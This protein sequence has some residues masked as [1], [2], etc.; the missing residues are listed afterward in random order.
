[1][2]IFL[3]SSLSFWFLSL[4]KMSNELWTAIIPSLVALL[5]A[6]AGIF[7]DS[8]RRRFIGPRLKAKFEMSEPFIGFAAI[9][10]ASNARIERGFFFRVG[11]TNL[12]KSAAERVNILLTRLEK[13]N[14]AVRRYE[15]EEWF[16]PIEL[17]WCHG[18]GSHLQALNPHSTIYF[19]LGHIELVDHEEHSAAHPEGS[20]G[21]QFILKTSRIDARAAGYTLKADRYQLRIQVSAANC[22]PIEAWFHMQ[23]RPGWSD[24]VEDLIRTGHTRIAL[25]GQHPQSI[26]GAVEDHFRREMSID[27]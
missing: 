24:N 10:E 5:V 6:L 18:I 20:L 22:Q 23:S 17:D 12:G 26:L 1:M 16:V 27:S 11:V 13:Y 21:K 25:L 8:I 19:D 15:V 3:A 14:D 4:P 2:L 7:Q 9:R